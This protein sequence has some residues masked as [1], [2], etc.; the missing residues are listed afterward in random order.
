MTE[1]YAVQEKI[2]AA[3]P[4]TKSA[5]R[6]GKAKFTTPRDVLAKVDRDFAEPSSTIGPRVL[7]SH[8]RD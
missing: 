3:M 7:N 2:R 4:K 6:R 5:V 8:L 1:I